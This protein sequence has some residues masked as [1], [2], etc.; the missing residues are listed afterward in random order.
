[1][2]RRKGNGWHSSPEPHIV[3]GGH[4]LH[5][6]AAAYRRHFPEAV[7]AKIQEA[8]LICEHVFDLLGS[9]PRKLS[10]SGAGYRPIDWHSDFKSGYRWNA[11]QFHRNIRYGHIEGVDIKVPWELSRFGHLNLLGQAYLLTND[12]RYS[13]EFMDQITDWIDNNPVGFGVNWKCTM[14]VAIRAANWLVA[15]EFFYQESALP[16]HFRR[17][18]CASVHEHG[19]FIRHH[20]E[21]SGVTGNHYI[22]DIGGLFFIATYCPFFEEADTWRAFCIAELTKEIGKQTHK[23]GCDFEGSTAYH[24]LVL[25]MFFYCKLL[26]DHAG[27][28]LPEAYGHRLRKMF[29]VSLYCIKS[30]GMIPQIGDNDNG[31]FLAFT[32]RPI[33]EHKYILTLA[34]IYYRD[35]DFKL[36]GFKFDE[37]AFW[38]FGPTGKRVY[39]KLQTRT[40]QLRPK[41]FPE[42][43]WFIIRHNNDYCFISCGADRQNGNRGHAHNDRLSLELVLDGRDVIVD[44][45]TYVYT[46]YPNERNRF[47]STSYHNT[48]AFDGCEQNEV[49]ND[50]VF[51]L[52]DQV[53]VRK[54]ILEEDQDQARFEGEIEYAGIRHRRTVTLSKEL[55]SW[56]IEDVIACSQ[57]LKATLFFHLAPDFIRENKDIIAKETKDKVASIEIPGQSLERGDY[58]YSPSYGVKMTAEY[59]AIDIL[60]PGKPSKAVTTS[61]CRR[62][63]A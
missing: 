13:T 7:Q 50:D 43:G 24:R 54:A 38:L 28:T 4:S 6:L 25:E 55:G 29:E 57:P 56:Q 62:M 34:S 36:S 39:D 16:A 44:P 58:E 61:I 52:A 33:L 26:A 20:L 35:S 9:G 11:R 22:A 31:R 48:I 23:D 41:S 59:V 27:T 46:P 47:R 10:A 8:D 1:L 21:R 63:T 45:G 32:K 30:N 2:Y 5:E 17:R 19:K 12:H 42:A 40:S 60:E 51:K 3:G 49:S 37:E 15:S 14:D 18:F 53:R